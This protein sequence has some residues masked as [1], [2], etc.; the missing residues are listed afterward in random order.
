ML[1]DILLAIIPALLNYFSVISS[2]EYETITPVAVNE[3]KTVVNIYEPFVE[4]T[5]EKKIDPCDVN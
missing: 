5:R 2:S 1:R 4:E 3:E